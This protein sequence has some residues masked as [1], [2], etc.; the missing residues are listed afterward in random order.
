MYSLLVYFITHR[1][2]MIYKNELV[3]MYYWLSGRSTMT[4][5]YITDFKAFE[6]YP[7]NELFSLDYTQ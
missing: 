6:I 1:T 2:E 7:I 3:C 5:Y 4:L